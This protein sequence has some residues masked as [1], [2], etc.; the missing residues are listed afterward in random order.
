MSSLSGVNKK[1]GHI[2]I[3][4]EHQ[5]IGEPVDRN[6][7]NNLPYNFARTTGIA[8]A[9]ITPFRYQNGMR[10]F[11]RT[12]LDTSGYLSLYLCRTF[13]LQLLRPA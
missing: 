8:N 6:I 10:L 11:T 12:L 9:L 2:T 7:T 4:S 1:F 13:T 3:I 5:H